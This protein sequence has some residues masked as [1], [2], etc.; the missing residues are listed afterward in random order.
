MFMGEYQHTLDEKGRL[1]IPA[2]FREALGDR[3]IATRGL[4]Q[5]LFVF[6]AAEWRHLEEKLRT[7]P[8][9][10]KDARAFLRLLFSGASECEA[11]KQGRVML[12]QHLRE[13]AGLE[14]EVVVI[15]VSTRA[16]IWSKERWEAYSSEAASVYAELA[17]K[18]VSAGV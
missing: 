9:T 1:F 3:F 10:Q 18:I 7:L 17:E 2:R 6:P 15:G 8:M 12:P 4:E 5:C 11:D 16:E 13:Y 14:K